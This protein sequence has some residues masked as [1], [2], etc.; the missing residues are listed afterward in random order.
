MNNYTPLV[1]RGNDKNKQLTLLSL[2]KRKRKKWARPQFR[3][4]TN[5]TCHQKPNPS[6]ETV[7]LNA[8]YTDTLS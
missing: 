8:C 3:P 6:R 4:K 7:H 1:I 2:R 5:H